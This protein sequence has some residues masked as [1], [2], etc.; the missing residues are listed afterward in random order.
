MLTKNSKVVSIRYKDLR[1]DY[2]TR[3]GGSCDALQ[4][5]AVRHHASC[6][7]PS[8]SAYQILA[9]LGNEQLSY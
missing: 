9:Q 8:A 4:L 5:Q 1:Q 2:K 3:K 7:G 6:S